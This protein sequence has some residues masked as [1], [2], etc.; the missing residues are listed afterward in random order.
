MSGTRLREGWGRS[1]VALMGLAALAAYVVPRLVAAQ[2]Q[3][4][5]WDVDV[6]WWGG[7]Q[8]LRR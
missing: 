6:Y 2:P 5:M 3:W 1:A 8:A 4:P 7:R